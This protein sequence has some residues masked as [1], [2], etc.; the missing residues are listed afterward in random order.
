MSLTLGRSGRGFLETAPGDEVVMRCFL[1]TKQKY[2]DIVSVLVSLLQYLIINI[3]TG[4]DIVI[5]EQVCHSNPLY[6]RYE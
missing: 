5:Y 2:L 1:E 6:L 3:R 4:Y